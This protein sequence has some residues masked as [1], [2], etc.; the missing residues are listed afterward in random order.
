MGD[1]GD[2][3]GVR[4]VY[5]K[6]ITMITTQA[7]PGILPIELGEGL[8]LRRSSVE[9]TDALADFNAR[10]HS[11]EG[12]DQPDEKVRAWTY[13]LMAKPHPTFRAS[14]FTIVEEVT[15]SRIVSAMNLIP[16]TW[17]FA[18]IPFKVGRPELVGTL[19][20]Y[21]KRGLVRRQ[22]EIIHQWSA[23]NGDLVQ[24]ITG[25]PYYYRQFGYEMA[26][27]LG[28][29]R[30]GFPT[31]IPRLNDGEAEPYRIRPAVEADISFLSNLYE[32]SCKRSLVACE[33]DEAQW[34]Y[35]LRG[36]GEKNVN[37][38]EVR[39]IETVDGRP[40]GFITHPGFSWGD[41][42]AAQ[43]YEI[44]PE[45]SWLEVTPSVIRYLETTYLQLHPEHGGKKPFGAFGFWLG[46]AHPVY[47]ILPDHL[48]RVRK[49]Y[50]WYLRVPDVVYFLKLITPVLEQRLI[51]SS[52]AGYSG[53]IKITF[54]R[55]GVRMVLEKGR[56]VTIETW[57][58][59][60][61]RHEGLS[62]N[63]GFPPHTFLQLLFGYRTLESLKAS[64]ADCWTDRDEIHALLEA[65]F[66]RQ[67]SDVWPVS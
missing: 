31:H 26:M 5:D 45:F 51:A 52:M 62:G 11:D 59:E 32:F 25:I 48:P 63:A 38:A 53:E 2:R 54:Y 23:Q 20:E 8:I 7:N 66:P 55:G 14:D 13:D 17:A 21:R 3:L 39:V 61:L 10:V 36:K 49:P 24:A 47:G 6:E 18:G 42:L 9:D 33:W 37:R 40:C 57:S 46:E 28:G 19:P 4:A 12:P 27:N 43:R 56:L 50:A 67:P 16:Q 64:F 60:L 22:F 1:V 34:R 65:L 35:E 41:M 44:L 30:M 58:P 15:S 29:G